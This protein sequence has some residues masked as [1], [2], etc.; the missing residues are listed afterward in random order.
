M[1]GHTNPS[2]V[3]ISTLLYAPKFCS[4]DVP[5]SCPEWQ[6]PPNFNNK[7]QDIECI[8]AAIEA[9]NKGGQVN[10]LNL[11]YE[12]IRIAKKEGKVMHRHN[13]ETPIW[14]EREVRR[15]LHLTPQYKA[16][17]VRKTAKIFMGGLKNLGNWA[18]C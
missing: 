7:R 12:G 13:P 6:P 18:Q 14:R 10:Y 4:L 1:N 9:M 17:V 15:K 8:N 16:K 2:I 3:S 5:A 11:H